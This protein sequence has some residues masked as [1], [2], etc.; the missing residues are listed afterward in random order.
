MRVL[1]L[2]DAA[3]PHT[4]KWA[5]ALA[6]K[7]IFI[8]VFSLNACDHSLYKNAQSITFYE[9]GVDPSFLRKGNGSPAKLF[10]LFVLKKLKNCIRL[11]QPDIVHAHYATS[12]GL[13]GALI[14]FHPYIISV[15]GSDVFDFPRKSFLHKGILKFNL[16]KA[17]KVLSTSHVM[18]RETTLYT[19]KPIEVTPF[20]IDV[21]IFCPKK[22][23]SVFLPEDIVVGTVKTLETKYGI[24]YLVEAFA[25]V[26][27]KHPDLPLKLLIVGGGSQEELLCFKARELQIDKKTTFTGKIPY[28]EVQKWHRMLSVSVSVSNSES[29][30][31]AVIEASA[32]EKPVVVSNVGGLPEVVEDGVTGIIVPPRDAEATAAAIERLVLDKN[33][34]RKMG[35]A[36]RR[37]VEKLF[38]WAENVEQMLG[39]YRGIL[40]TK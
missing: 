21:N 27:R 33:L 3:S 30:G 36:G 34:R 2:A 40:K 24:E 20:G 6:G 12:Y 7:N 18:A 19:D 1:L 13:I 31:V 22:E 29:F 23:E 35:K 28:T 10:Y 11:F 15:W 25:L 5:D 4:I 16:A 38:N 17:D 9:C 39:I 14:G 32:C 8:A 37:R 26:I